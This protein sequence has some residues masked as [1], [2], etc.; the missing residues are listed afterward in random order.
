MH[1]VKLEDTH[2]IREARAYRSLQYGNEKPPAGEPD[3]NLPASETNGA[4]VG[5]SVFDQHAT[6]YKYN[7]ELRKQE[8]SNVDPEGLAI[9]SV[10]IYNKSGQVVESRQPKNAAGGGAGTTKTVYYKAEKGNGGLINCESNA[11]AG[12]PCKVEPAAQESGTG[13][14]QLLVKKFMRYNQLGEVEEVVESPGGGSENVRKTLLTYDAAGRQKTKKIEGGGQTIPKIETEYSEQNG[15]PIAERFKCEAECEAPQFLTSIG[16]ASQGHTGLKNPSDVAVDASGNIWAVDKGNNRIVEYN[17]AGEFL[18]EAGGA[19]SSG[20]KL[21]SPSGIAID[22]SGNVDVAD[23]AN[24]RVAQFSSSGA[25]IEVIGANVNKTKVEAGGT[26]LEKNRCTAASGNV[27]QAGTAGSAEGQISEPIGITTTG[28][29]TFFVVERANNRVEKLSPLAEVLARFGELGSGNGQLKEPA[30]I[31]FHGFLLWVADTGNN[32]MEAFTTSYA[33]SRQFGTQGSGN[34]QLSK[35]AGVDAD[36]SG[37]VWVSEQGNNRV[38]KFSETG[39]Y[40]LK[41]GAAGTEEGQFNLSMPAGL[42]L[43]GKGN[44]FVADPGNNRIQKWSTSGFDSQETR[45]SYDSLGRPVTYEDADGN[46]SETTYDLDGRPVKTTDAKSSQTLHYDANSGM[47]V[48]LEDSAAGVFTASYDADGNLVKRGLPDGLVAETTYNEADEPTHLTYTKSSF[49]G[50]SCTWLDFGV[51]RTVFGQ[52]VTESG[53]LGT[54]HFSYDKDGRL[55]YANETPPGGQCTTRAYAYDPDSNRFLK[56][57]RSP[58][59]GGTCAESGGTTQEYKYDAADRLEGPTYDSWGRITNLPA[60]YA[61]GKTLTTS[62]FSDD[63]VASQSQNGISNTFQLDASLRQRQRLQGSGLEGTEVF[64]YDGP[65]DSPAWIQRGS[66][67]SRTIGSLGGE[68]AAIQEGGKEITLQLTNL[69]GDV[70]ATAAM[71]LEVSSLKGTS[72]F[73]EFGRPTSGSAG[74]FGWL[75]GKGRRTE[76]SSGVV[77]MGRRSYVPQLGRFLTPDPVFGGSANPYDYAN[78]DPVNKFDLGGECTDQYA[79]HGC[80]RGNAKGNRATS[81]QYYRHK[82]RQIEEAHHHANPVVT[83]RK[84]TAIACTVGWPSGGKNDGL[85]EQVV[86]SVIHYLT[87]HNAATNSEDTARYIESIYGASSSYAGSLAVGC[88]QGATEGWNETFEMRQSYPDGA[89]FLPSIL[90]TVAKCVVSS[91][92]R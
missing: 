89:G 36:A 78:Q 15:M 53:T 5:G 66:T 6:T 55:T 1:L 71:S 38:Q 56:T 77:Q 88:A 68:L 49:C 48:E 47:P 50:A 26:T 20:G 83:S 7:W 17:E 12:L 29:T 91:Q 8:E 42:A 9:R 51:E 31:A 84:C 41:F 60:E 40:L 81:R 76:L 70:S 34:G 24:N 35:P 14:P 52:I 79:R 80:R 82:A 33:Y 69:H 59:I 86:N 32:R 23:T 62:Y 21:S 73:D 10:S 22:S 4:L 65:F 44:V 3:Y 18:S 25:F 27:C 30:G 58:G 19:G 74:R 46:Q 43:D 75:G 16:Y 2:E 67:W 61:G 37:N 90:Y 72:T 85:V 11:Y 54:D 57:T 28:G 63:M 45:T 13:R 87:H 64:H 39:T 92:E